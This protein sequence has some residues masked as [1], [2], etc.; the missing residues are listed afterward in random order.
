DVSK[1]VIVIDT[2]KFMTPNS[3]GDFDTWHIVGIE[4]LPGTV[5]Y[6]YDRHGKLLKTLLST[7]VGWDGTYR[8]ENMPSDDYWFVAKVKKDGVDFDVKGH[9]ALKR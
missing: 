4:Q 6:I 3:D 9:F 7:S 2:P 1:E 5:V 8:G